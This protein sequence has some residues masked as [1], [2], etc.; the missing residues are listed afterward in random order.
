MQDTSWDTVGPTIATGQA[1]HVEAERLKG[2]MEEQYRLR[3]AVFGPVDATSRASSAYL[4]GKYAKMPKK[5]TAWGFPVDD[6]PPSK[7][8]KVAKAEK[9]ADKKPTA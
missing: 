2:L 8:A 3:D 5:L 9:K 7:A 1:Y 4:K 6:T